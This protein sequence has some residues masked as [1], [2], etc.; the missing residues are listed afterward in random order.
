[1]TK[2]DESEEGPVVEVYIAGMVQ[3]AVAKMQTNQPASASDSKS[4]KKVTLPLILK[5]AKNSSASWDWQCAHSPSQGRRTCH[6]WTK[7][8]ILVEQ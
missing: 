1:M 2:Q 3:V 8:G 4:T 6:S 5:Q 7:D